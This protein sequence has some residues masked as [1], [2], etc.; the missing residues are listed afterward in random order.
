[1]SSSSII[2]MMKAPIAG[3]V[4][5]RLSAI[6]GDEISLELHKAFVLDLLDSLL[7]TNLDIIA[8][9]HPPKGMNEVR[10]LIPD[11]IELITQEG[12]DLG[13]RQISSIE[14]MFDLGYDKVFVI[15]ADSPDVPTEHIRLAQE[16]LD[17]TDAV[18]GPS[19]DGGYYLLGVRKDCPLKELMEG[20]VWG[21]RTVTERIVKNSTLVGASIGIAPVWFDIDTVEDLTELRNR[22]HSG[23]K[24]ER[25]LS[26]LCNISGLGGPEDASE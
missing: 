11:N 14:K 23:R 26:I 8:A 18:I 9:Y 17:E 10:N 25:T 2:I 16:I 24:P 20:V 5:T 21:S 19:S 22:D 1:M 12:E 6:L 13:E 3:T 15:S 4:K 7:D